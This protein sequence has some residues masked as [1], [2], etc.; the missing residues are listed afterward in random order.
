[1]TDAQHI[2]PSRSVARPMTVD[3]P[4]HW[5]AS[6]T[7]S[8]VYAI[9]IY[10]TVPAL[11]AGFGF[12]GFSALMVVA[13]SVAATFVFDSLFS[14]LAHRPTL[15][16]HGG[17]MHTVL[18]GLLLAMSL[19][20]TV[21]W[22]V[23]VLAS[24][25]TV[26]IGKGLLGRYTWQPVLLGR[27]I[28]QVFFHRQLSLPNGPVLGPEH[29]CLGRLA[30]P[31]I[32]PMYG[33]WL[34]AVARRADA[35][36]L[37][38]PLAAIR[39][40]VGGQAE[41]VQQ[42]V[43]QVSQGGADVGTPAGAVLFKLIWAKLPA[44]TDLLIGAVPGEIGATCSIALLAGGLFLLYHG[45]IRW[46]MVLAFLF[47]AAAT[48][49]IAP[50]RIGLLDG[51]GVPAWRWFPGVQFHNGM[52]VG[53]L[54]VL[55]HLLSGGLLLGVFF[56]AGDMVSRPMTRRGQILFAIGCGAGTILIRLYAFIPAAPY[57]F[58]SGATYLA[59]LLMNTFTPLL[60]RISQP[61][62]FGH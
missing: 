45:Y 17:R 24:V 48:A 58:T 20:A 3:R 11:L 41:W 15:A 53:P 59:I 31:A 51:D 4:P 57:L 36:L 55:Y 10:A 25:A 18:M 60:D 44:V 30:D 5:R 49:A 12:F 50:L 56:F 27:L 26:V 23:V 38:Q 47:A 8:R 1:M 21:N 34:D 29:L 43:A 9:I 32:V 28:V 14:W 39:D 42:A 6:E 33:S 40:L 46:P 7:A 19:P 35:F 13:V 16:L 62:A 61:R 2:A 54:Y 37:P 22:L 52:P